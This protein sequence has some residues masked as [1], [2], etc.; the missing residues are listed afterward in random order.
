[1][2]LVLHGVAGP[3]A[4]RSAQLTQPE[5]VIGRDPSSNIPLNDPQLSR[6]HAKLFIPGGRWHLADL[7]STNGTF[8]NGSKIGAAP[9]PISDGAVLNIGGSSFRIE[10]RGAVAATILPP[11]PP[12]M[13]PIPPPVYTPPAKR[14]W[15][16]ALQEALSVY[17]KG[18][19]DVMRDGVITQAEAADLKRV[20][21]RLGLTDADTL[22]M[23][24][25]AFISLSDMAI[26]QDRP[27]LQDANN[28]LLDSLGLAGL[29]HPGV[30][31]ACTRA[32]AHEYLS[33]IRQGQMPI[34]GDSALNLADG[35]VSHVELGAALLEER[36]VNSGWVGGNTGVSFRVAKGVRFHVG[37]T[38]GRRVSE[39]AV[40]PVSHGLL[41]I[42]N[43]RIAFLGNP[44]SFEAKWSRVMGVE[45]FGDGLTVFIANRAKAP[46]VQYVQPELAEVVAAICSAYIS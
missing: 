15:G 45:P 23:R 17:E 28:H 4:G 20:Q 39:R 22:E 33:L 27:D 18:I 12:S 6:M 26:Q 34:C 16:R 42:T 40:V 36:V 46:T 29:G 25:S 21:D 30:V 43:H 3:Y 32:L 41:A 5:I 9:V 44:K 35:E 31:A 37:G 7:G 11:S 38:R 8:L 10:L 14:P 24:A 1:M 13:A 19:R 2:E